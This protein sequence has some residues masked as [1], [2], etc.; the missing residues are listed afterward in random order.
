MDIKQEAAGPPQ[1]VPVVADRMIHCSVQQV[2]RTGK[3]SSLFAGTFNGQLVTVE[4][5]MKVHLDHTVPAI[6]LKLNHLNVVKVFYS[7]ED[8]V[9]RLLKPIHFYN[10]KD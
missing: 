8:L 3:F 4:R 9:Y 2:L 6:L 7:E 10:L 1:V 5:V